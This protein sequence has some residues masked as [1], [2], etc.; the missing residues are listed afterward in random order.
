MDVDIGN[1]GRMERSRHIAPTDLDGRPV[2]LSEIARPHLRAIARDNSALAPHARASRN[3]LDHGFGRA[4][5]HVCAER[6]IEFEAIGVG[7]S[8]LQMRCEAVAR[9]NVETDSG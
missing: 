3:R 1:A 8:A 7:Q 4:T 9:Y 5:R 6:K 2:T